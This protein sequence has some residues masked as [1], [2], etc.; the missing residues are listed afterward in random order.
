MYCLEFTPQSAE[1]L[2]ILD[3]HLDAKYFLATAGK[4]FP[5]KKLG[6]IISI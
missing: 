2:G 3:F 1:L 4:N 5:K 6:N